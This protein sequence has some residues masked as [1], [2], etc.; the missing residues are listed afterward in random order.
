MKS[1]VLCEKPSVAR[2]IARNLGAKN[3]KN[4]CLEGDKYVVTWALGHLITLQTPDKYKEFNNVSLENLPMIPK[5]M[6][7][8][9]IKKTFKQYKVVENA[10]NR[11]D[12]NEVI[13]ATDAGREGELV[14]RYIIDKAKCNKNI[15]RLWISSVTDKAIKDGFR[16]LKDGKEYL[17]LY[18]SGIA[19][20]NADWLVGINASRA[21]TLKYNASLNCGRVQTPTLQ[22]VFEREEKIKQFK[23]KDYYT[24][25]A[26]IDGV[27][28][29]CGNSEFNLEKAEQ[30]IKKNINK[31]IKNRKIIDNLN[32][33]VEKG[34][35]IVIMGKSGS[36][37]STLLK[38]I[39]GLLKLDRGKVVIDNKNITSLNNEKLAEYRLKNIGIVFQDY[40]LLDIFTAYENIIFPARVLKKE[41]IK[42]IRNKANYFIKMANLENEKDKNITELSGGEKQRVAF[43]RGRGRR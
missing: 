24:F 34:E 18:H 21:L 39:A 7:T 26:Q 41:D 40:Q 4:G 43:A 9:I 32:L 28:F 16:N 1:V 13:I 10:L 42:T 8:E 36:G 30:F 27:K 25:E 15:K 38:I 23:P 35:F 17:G 6:K 14:A 29:S 20:A 11:K 31:E 19:R 22:M 3:N 2:D 33:F 37:K 5:F 12:V